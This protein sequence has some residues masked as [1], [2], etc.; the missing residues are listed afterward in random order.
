MLD[1]IP[2]TS[3]NSGCMLDQAHTASQNSD[4]TLDQSHTLGR[5]GRLP[6]E[7]RVLVYEFLPN[8][9]VRSEY[10]DA[11]GGNPP[12]S[13]ALITS[14]TQTA[15]L[16]TCRTIH[17]EAKPA[18]EKKMQGLIDEKLAPG[19][20]PHID[21]DPTAMLALARGGVF[22]AI[23]DY[24]V[25]LQENTTKKGDPD[26]ILQSLK[27][28]MTTMLRVYTPV[29]I[30]R[31]Q[32]ITRILEFVRQASVMLYKDLL[33][34]PQASTIPT[35]T[36]LEPRILLVVLERSK[37]VREA[38]MR[39]IFDSLKELNT[40]ADMLGLRID[41]HGYSTARSTR[42]ALVLK[43]MMHEL[44]LERAWLL[45][46]SVWRLGTLH[47]IEIYREDPETLQDVRLWH[48]CE[49]L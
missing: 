46:G 9:T 22:T 11:T 49:W 42:L 35:T 41:A 40:S 17:K 24:Y 26:A 31:E 5:F 3:Q 7:L 19:P 20:A 14:S 2:T 4:N 37:D 38:E 44:D 30:S 33:C 15:L 29:G 10:R 12:S 27:S 1:Q 36:V 48:S 21:A 16:A 13:F 23:R 45:R 25:K 32:G 47:G 28:T 8:R 18:L 39:Q 43:S 34:N 6:S